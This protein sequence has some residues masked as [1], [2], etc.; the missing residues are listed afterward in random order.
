MRNLIKIPKRKF[1]KIKIIINKLER[2]NFTLEE[3]A[4]VSFNNVGDG[5]SQIGYAICMIDNNGNL[6][7]NFE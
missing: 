2:N 5:N 3:Y 6:N 4:H 7:L 1:K